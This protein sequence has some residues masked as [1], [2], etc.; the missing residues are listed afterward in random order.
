VHPEQNRLRRGFERDDLFIVGSDVVMTDSL[1]YADVVLPACSH[2]EHPDLF[3]AYGQHWLQRSEPVIPPQGQALPNTEIFRRL[4]R[5]FGFTDPAFSATDEELMDES[6]DAADPRL[7]GVR[8][9]RIPT[10]RALA[11][12]AAGEEFVLFGNVFPKTPSGKVEL[13]STYLE[14]KYAAPLADYR[15]VDSSYP[16]ALI[17]PAS[18]KRIT[19]TFGGCRDSAPTPPLEMH[20]DDARAR[21]LE[22]GARVK[23]WNDL[24]E[25]HLTLEITDAVPPGV[26]CS[27]KGAW[28]RTS[29]N[30]Q[31]VSALAPAT[32]ADISEG[33]CYNDARVEVAP[34]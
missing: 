31:T 22:D 3:A 23:V 19:A 2:F 7:G 6:L 27:L 16:L 30:G 8:P 13:V 33:A 1:A 4:A 9:S 5:R 14:N 12:T 20:P 29:D 10:D 24:G 26:V 18:D 25:V 15:P 11:M 21:G 34:L 17:S 28:M 32:H